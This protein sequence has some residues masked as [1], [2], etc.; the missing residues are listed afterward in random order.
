[1]AD[2]PAPSDPRTEPNDDG[3]RTQPAESPLRPALRAFKL[4]MVPFL[5]SWAFAYVGSARGIEWLYFAGL[6]GVSLSLIVL[7]IWLIS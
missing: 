5:L 6:G 2:E 7:M 3:D 1:M 4:F